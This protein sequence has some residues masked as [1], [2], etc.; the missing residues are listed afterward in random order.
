VVSPQAK[1]DAVGY[2]ITQ[3]LLSERRACGLAKA[4][5]TTQRYAPLV[6]EGS[7]EKRLKELATKRLAY[8]YRRLHAI[9]KKEGHEINHKKVYRLYRKNNLAK[10]KRK[11]KKY[12]KQER[13]PL[14]KATRPNERWAMD[15]MS[16]SCVNGRKLRT[17]NILDLF[18]RECIE[19]VVG[20]SIPSSR[21]IATLESISRE[22][23]LPKVIT[24]DN[25]PEYT[26]KIIREWAKEKGVE[27]D[28][29]TPGRPMENGYIE[30][31]NGK[32]RDECLDQNWFI[33]LPKASK[34][35]EEW[36]NDYNNERPHSALGYLS[37]REYLQK[38]E[39]LEKV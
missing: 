29:I 39:K 23:G 18:A 6:N 27:L 15:F 20:R 35:I 33:D 11:K 24:V 14:K 7:I 17:L 30:S 10:R 9:L 34:C 32:F 5:R 26:S 2:L 19:I 16:D 28:Y 38:H 25:G 22:R 13:K 12:V 36:R 31:F 4:N 21:V 1:R 37:P 8:R 3:H